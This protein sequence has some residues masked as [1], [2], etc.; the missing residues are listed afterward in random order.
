MRKT[1]NQAVRAVRGLFARMVPTLVSTE[2]SDGRV[3][4]LAIGRSG[5]EYHISFGQGA[6]TRVRNGHTKHAMVT[7]EVDGRT[8]GAFAHAMDAARAAASLVH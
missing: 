5:K 7:V 2:V 1:T 6:L 3:S 4:I 8:V